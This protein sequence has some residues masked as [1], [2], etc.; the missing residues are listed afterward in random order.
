M[1]KREKRLTKRE[2]K[3]LRGDSP[4]P[5]PPVVRRGAS[6]NSQGGALTAG[7][8][9]HC[10]ACGKHLETVGEPP[11]KSGLAAP[12]WTTVQCAHG[13]S[14]HACV[15][16]VAKAKALLDEHDRTGAEPKVAAAWH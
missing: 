10:I 7:S 9:I 3:S 13:G 6:V 1:S 15:G 11:A 2:Q 5:N 16:C 4:G 8:H 14:F 12:P